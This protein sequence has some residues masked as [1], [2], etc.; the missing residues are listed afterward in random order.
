MAR[1]AWLLLIVPA[2]ALHLVNHKVPDMRSLFMGDT[3][4]ASVSVYVINLDKRKD[5]WECVE[6]QLQGSPYRYKRFSAIDKHSIQDSCPFMRDGRPAM[7]VLCS[8][9]KIWEQEIAQ[10][11]SDFVVVI[12][13]DIALSPK[14]WERLGDLM[15]G[16]C[17]DSFDYLVVDT[18][19]GAG[20]GRH[21][22][23]QHGTGFCADASPGIHLD[24]IRGTGAHMQVIRRSALQQMLDI[25][26]ENPRTP[27]D[28]MNARVFPE[29]LRTGMFLANIAAQYESAKLIG[30]KKKSLGCHSSVAHAD[31]N[32]ENNAGN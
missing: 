9:V 13:D 26:K 6:S 20:D 5:R 18:F 25:A 4:N 32:S 15:N 8:N 31:I 3:K 28:Q 22:L 29:K 16:Q 12:E 1:L 27:I 7:G 23:S 2:W 30:V 11:T 21:A 10:G 24:K 19:G 17:K 14:V